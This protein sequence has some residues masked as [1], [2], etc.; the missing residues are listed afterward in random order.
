MIFMD[1]HSQA[2]V[3]SEFLK[4][5]FG[6]GRRRVRHDFGPRWIG[7]APKDQRRRT[8]GDQGKDDRFRFNAQIFHMPCYRVSTFDVER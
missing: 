7:N 5:D 6:D 3:E 1:D 4:G 2:V 8:D